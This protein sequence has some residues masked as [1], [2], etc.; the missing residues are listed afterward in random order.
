MSFAIRSTRTGNHSFTSQ[1]V[2]I[3]I[4]NDIFKATR[5]KIDLTKPDFELFIEIRNENAYLYTEKIRGA[6]GMPQGT[7]GKLLALIDNSKSILAAW[8]LM[9]RGCSIVF[10]NT[11]DFYTDVLNLFISSWYVES[12]TIM[13]DPKETNLYE[14]L[15]KIVKEKKCNAIVTGHSIYENLQDILNEIRLLKKHIKLPILNPLIGMKKEDINKK[16]KD[17]GIRI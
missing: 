10:A 16:C 1:D 9:R 15:N 11:S 3:R 6:G 7:Q 13:I 4:G 14:K 2:A 8:Y 5:S 12:E 17:I